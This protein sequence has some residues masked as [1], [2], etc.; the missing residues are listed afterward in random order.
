MFR[1]P[2][3]RREEREGDEQAAQLL[4]FV[5]L[6]GRGDL[7]AS[8]L[9]YGEQRRLEIAR[10]L[11]TQPQLLL[12]DEP[13][14]GTTR[15]EKADLES[16]IRRIRD[17][18]AITVLLIEHD[19]RLVMALADRVV[20]L[21]FGKVIASGTPAEVQRHPAVVEAYLGTSDSGD[22]DGSAEVSPS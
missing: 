5:G 22:G 13:A 16:L 4:E 21:N 10:A 14:A 19:M 18:M 17:E 7:V 15:K 2:R 8:G 12:L 1:L 11:G 3:T 20:V 6:R 9:A